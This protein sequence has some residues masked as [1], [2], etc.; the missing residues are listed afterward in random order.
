V[1]QGD[2]G[3]VGKVFGNATLGLYLLVFRTAT[4]VTQEL[5]RVVAEVAVPVFSRVQD[6]TERLGSGV[7]ETL[8]AV[9]AVVVPVGVFLSL[10]AG[11][12]I[13]LFLGPRWLSGVPVFRVLLVLGVLRSFT[14]IA[15]VALIARGQMPYITR[16]SFLQL[17]AIL[18]FAFPMGLAFGL[19]GLASGVC[20]AQILPMIGFVKRVGTLLGRRPGGVLLSLRGPLLA[21]SLGGILAG[22]LLTLVSGSGVPDVG[23]LA[24]GI[25]VFSVAYLPVVMFFLRRD[26]PE[27]AE[28]VKGFLFVWP[29]HRVG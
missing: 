5:S 23:V 15:Q 29:G 20:F 6:D 3:F 19:V 14:Q 2:D 7:S 21:S 24:V 26:L 11:P 8:G 17:L 22:G 1:E 13:S 16:I 10:F 12:F 18:L 25:A 4:M 9:G 28:L 27:T